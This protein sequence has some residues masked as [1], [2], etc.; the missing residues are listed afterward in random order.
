MLWT[1]IYILLSIKELLPV[2]NGFL[3]EYIACWNGRLHRKHI[4]QL[5]EYVRPES[6][7]GQFY[8]LILEIITCDLLDL[9]FAL[10]R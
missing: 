5:L 8:H 10:Y 3:A 9:L 4:F 6:F 2:F 1:S 7:D